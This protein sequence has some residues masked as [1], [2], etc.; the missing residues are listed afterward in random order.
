MFRRWKQHGVICSVNSCVIHVERFRCGAIQ[1]YLPLT[2]H[3][4]TP[5]SATGV[6]IGY[7]FEPSFIAGYVWL[8]GSLVMH[9]SHPNTTLSVSR[10]LAKVHNKSSACYCAVYQIQLRNRECHFFNLWDYLIYLW[11]RTLQGAA[12]KTY[13][14]KNLIFSQTDRKFKTKFSTLIPDIYAHISIKYYWKISM[15][16][17]MRLIWN[18][19][20]NFY[21]LPAKIICEAMF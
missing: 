7:N 17:T 5:L 20:F 1:I 8:V 19:S 13:H 6:C 11:C 3:H 9:C 15:R 14:D 16:R 10:T 4:S 21:Y 2:I 18:E 12:K